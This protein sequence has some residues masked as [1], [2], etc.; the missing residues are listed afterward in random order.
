MRRT[1]ATRLAVCA[2]AHQARLR[3]WYVTLSEA[4][5][6]AEFERRF[7]PGSFAWLDEAVGDLTLEQIQTTVL[8]DRY[9]QWRETQPWAD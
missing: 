5:Q 2:A 1:L 4:E 7:G 8:W 9:Q 3:Q 6:R